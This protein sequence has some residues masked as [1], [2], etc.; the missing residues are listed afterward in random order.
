MYSLKAT[1]QSYYESLD[2]ITFYT[3]SVFHD[4]SGE[5]WITNRKLEEFH[6]F[7]SCLCDK[8]K[9]VPIPPCYHTLSYLASY[10][11]T[12]IPD[13]E[14]FLNLIL[15]I[16][17]VFTSEEIYTFFD[18]GLHVPKYKSIKVSIESKHETRYVV[19]HLLDCGEYSM[20]VEVDYATVHRLEQYLKVFGYGGSVMSRVKVFGKTGVSEY[21]TDHVI[22][23][24]A[25]NK[26]HN[27]LILGCETGNLE[28]LK[29]SSVTGSFTFQE[30]RQTTAHYK[31]V[32]GIITEEDRIYSCDEEGRLI[33]ISTEDQNLFIEIT[34]SFLPKKMSISEDINY[35]YFCAENQFHIFDVNCYQCVKSV[36]VDMDSLISAFIVTQKGFVIVG[37]FNGKVVVYSNLCQIIH[38][39]SVAATVSCI[40]F[41]EMAMLI[42]VAD[43][44]GVVSI[45]NNSGDAIFRW[46]THDSTNCVLSH[47]SLCV[48]SGNDLSVRFW[49][50]IGIHEQ[51]DLT[52]G[53][54]LDS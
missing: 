19:Q 39:F 53:S 34:L 35:L 47:Q 30:I 7:Y 52:K 12:I 43:Q 37:G 21:R 27:L 25:Y 4:P 33:I 23:S 29:L 2:G 28:L 5:N 6:A 15:E 20:S 40:S 22:T 17:S 10:F 38:K 3:I 18:V 1:V 9:D 24:I 8:F 44:N 14:K 42:F 45:W 16:P 51:Q 31:P 49:K 46:K 32:R 36:D 41:D 48:T 11:T 50:L 13:L 26:N 54:T